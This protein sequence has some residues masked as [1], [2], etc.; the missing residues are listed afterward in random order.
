MKVE[1]ALSELESLRPGLNYVVS[2]DLHRVAAIPGGGGTPEQY[3]AAALGP[4]AVVG[5]T[6]E[7][8]AADMLTEVERCIR[9]AGDRGSHPDSAAI[10]SPRLDELVACVLSHMER[11]AASYA[12]VRRFWLLSG[13]PHY[14]VQWDFA[15]V[16]AGTGGAEVFIGSS[17]D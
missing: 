2:L 1:A 8:T 7:V 16:L 17:S 9:W 4:K 13:H 11:A 12:F 5:G 3:V 10:R 6:A 15:Y 14:P